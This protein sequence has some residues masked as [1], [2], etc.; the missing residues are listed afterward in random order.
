MP[1]AMSLTMLTSTFPLQQGM[2]RSMEHSMRWV[3]IAVTTPHFQVESV[4]LHHPAKVEAV[5]VTGSYNK[6]L[7]KYYKERATPGL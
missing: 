7:L 5:S 4:P 6:I 1:C 2:E 3:R